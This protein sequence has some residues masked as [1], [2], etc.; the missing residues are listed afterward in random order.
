MA[1]TPSAANIAPSGSTPVATF[2]QSQPSGVG[3]SQQTVKIQQSTI[4]DAAGTG[5]NAIAAVVDNNGLHVVLQQGAPQNSGADS[6]SI[7]A[8]NNDN[9]SS[10]AITTGKKGSLQHAIF[11]ATFAARWQLQT[12][13]NGSS[14]T[15]ITT[16]L[17]PPGG[18]FDFRAAMN[19]EVQTVTQTGSNVLFTVLCTN[20]DT[21]DGTAFAT[22]FWAEN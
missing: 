13:D 8:G 1:V 12:L 14:A 20:V 2:D 6:A 17:T 5:T 10:Q 19:N 18:T 4:V 16:I 9:I 11:A 22:F 3:G 21:V 15:P 7:T